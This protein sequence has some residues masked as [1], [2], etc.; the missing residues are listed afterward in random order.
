VTKIEDSELDKI[1]QYLA[2]GGRLF[3]LFNFR[4]IDR[5]SGLERTGLD[6]ILAKWGVE[7]RNTII[8]DPDNDVP[9]NGL[10]LRK[11]TK[12][13]AVNPLV[14]VDSGIFLLHPRSVAKLSARAKAAD[15]PPVEEIAFAGPKAFAANE[16][17]NCQAFPL[18]VAVEKGAVKG[19]T[20]ERGTTRMIVV[21]DS[22]FLANLF[23]Q[24]ARNRD[25]VGYAANWLLDRTQLLEGIGPRP[26]T[27]YRILMTNAQLQTA[28]WVL[29]SA[30][31]GSVLLL[32]GLVWLRRR[33]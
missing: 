2:Q 12:H 14:D 33:K 30:L 25:F 23:I 8:R 10:I 27:D 31:P 6:R 11:F 16:P 24:S 28:R 1:D 7:L 18:M 29:L 26:L 13:P 20:T 4:S 21:G 19:V 5:N 15:A 22:I 17:S 3:A 9:K 32:G